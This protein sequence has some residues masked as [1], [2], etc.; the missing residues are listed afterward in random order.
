M[1]ELNPIAE[2]RRPLVGVGVIVLNSQK[3]ILLGERIGSHGA[4]TWC[5]PGGHL[6]FGET[7]EECARRETLEETGL[8]LLNLRRGPYTNDYFEEESKHYITTFIIADSVGDAAE[9]CEPD[10]CL[11]WK[12]FD[13]KHQP[14]ALFLP[15][16]NLLLSGFT[17]HE[18]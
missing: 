6:E 11:Q 3:Q 10:K 18:Q 4:N 9:I 15:N 13:W 5:S 16:K 1:T 2:V 12:W 14:D 7:V 8:I 17:P